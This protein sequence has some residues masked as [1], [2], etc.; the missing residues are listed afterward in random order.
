MSQWFKNKRQEW[1]KERK[2]P[3]SRIDM[4]KEFDITIAVITNDIKAYQKLNN[5]LIY[6]RN[7]K[8]F[9]KVKN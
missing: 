9:E 6:N 5:D 7:L 3:F 4:A 8:Q 1:I 2:E